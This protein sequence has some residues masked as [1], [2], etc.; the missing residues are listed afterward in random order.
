MRK[1]YLRIVVV[2]V[3]LFVSCSKE[4][5][6]LITEEEGLC[7][8]CDGFTNSEAVLEVCKNDDNTVVRTLYLS[9]IVVYN[10]VIEINNSDAF[11]EL[12]CSEFDDLYFY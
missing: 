11:L 3:I 7:K 6:S 9:G 5:D 8:T 10:D 12:S 2:L 4:N 1:I